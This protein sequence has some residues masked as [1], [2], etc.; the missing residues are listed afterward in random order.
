MVAD[1]VPFVAAVLVAEAV[2]L[3]L[4]LLVAAFRVLVRPVRWLTRGLAAVSLLVGAAMAFDVVEELRQTDYPLVLPGQPFGSYA[5]PTLL[6][7]LEMV[8]VGPAVVVAALLAVRHP[9]PAGLLFLAAGVVDLLGSLR[10][11]QDSTTPP[12]NATFGVVVA[13]VPPLAVGALLLAL[14]WADRRTGL[15]TAPRARPAAPSGAG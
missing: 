14:W 15:P 12:G 4:A 2:L 6:T 3:L 5:Q 10:Q 9:R 1:A 13:G 8:A 11:Y 7:L